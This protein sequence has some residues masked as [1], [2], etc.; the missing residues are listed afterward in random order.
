MLFF[1]TIVSNPIL[2]AAVQFVDVGTRLLFSITKLY[3]KLRDA[4]HQ[5]LSDEIKQLVN[6]VNGL[7]IEGAIAD[8]AAI[9]AKTFLNDCVALC[10]Q[11]EDILKKI[12]VDADDSTVRKAWKAV[13]VVN[14][15]EQI[16]EICAQLERKKCALSLWIS[17]NSHARLAH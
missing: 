4:P 10:H 7:M 12:L 3:R 13:V 16:R 17:G 6:L 15:E 5:A 1:S 2:A 14:K 9:T 8:S 11:L